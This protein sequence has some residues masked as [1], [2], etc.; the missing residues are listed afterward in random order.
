[1]RSWSTESVESGLEKGNWL[2]KASGGIR[3]SKDRVE[4]SSK[5]QSIDGRSG[6]ASDDRLR[7]RHPRSVLLR[8]R[9]RCP[10]GQNDGGFEGGIPDEP[11]LDPVYL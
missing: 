1:M 2:Y 9:A 10:H 6:R 4:D 5:V 3:C 7:L 8:Q 11:F